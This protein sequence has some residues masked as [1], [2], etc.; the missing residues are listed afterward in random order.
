MIQVFTDVNRKEA[1][2]RQMERQGQQFQIS[3]YQGMAGRLNKFFNHC[4]PVQDVDQMEHGTRLDHSKITKRRIKE[5]IKNLRP[6]S[7]AGPDR[8]GANLLHNIREEAAPALRI[9]TRDQWTKGWCLRI[10]GGPM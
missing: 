2:T 8:I 1:R 4:E 3:S 6:N 5:K 7:A 10:G 9:T